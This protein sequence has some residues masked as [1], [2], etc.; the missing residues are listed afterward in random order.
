MQEKTHLDVNST[1]FSS[2][3]EPEVWNKDKKTNPFHSWEWSILNFPSILTRNIT[4]HSIMS[5]AFHSLLSWKLIILPILT[6]S[7]SQ[8]W[9]NVLFELGSDRVSTHPTLSG[10]LCL[11]FLPSLPNCG[12]KKRKTTTR[13]TTNVFSVPARSPPSVT[14]P[15]VVHLIENSTV[16]PKA[17]DWRQ[18]SGVSRHIPNYFVCYMLSM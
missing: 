14:S 15:H 8:V 17:L 2:E 3:G 4:S 18:D 9:E 11:S 1:V 6:T 12:N 10:L 5:L 16:S 7:L 13:T